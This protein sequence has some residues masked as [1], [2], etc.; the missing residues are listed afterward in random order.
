VPALGDIVTL[1]SGLQLKF[2]ILTLAPMVMVQAVVP[3]LELA[4]MYTSSAF[5]GADAP[6]EP[7]DVADHLVFAVF[8]VPPAPTQYLSAIYLTF[9]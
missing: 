1:A 6:A 4:S 5:V 3:V 2:L 7:P 9:I 8:Q